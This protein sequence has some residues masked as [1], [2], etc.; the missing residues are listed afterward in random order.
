MEAYNSCH[1]CP[2]ACGVDRTLG[3][4]G[5]CGVSATLT[6]AR[7]MLHH[8]EEPCISGDK[9]SGTIFF[10]GCPLGCIYCQNRPIATARVGKEVPDGRLEEIFWELEAQGAHNINLVT[11][12]LTLRP[13]GFSFMPPMYFMNQPL[14]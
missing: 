13:V 9:G 2:R 5:R 7:A 6:L 4:R 11:A 14:M 3:E 12:T 1:L 10:S 8:W